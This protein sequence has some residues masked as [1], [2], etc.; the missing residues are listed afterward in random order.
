MGTVIQEVTVAKARLHLEKNQAFERG[1]EGTNRP[2]NLRKVNDYAV[3]MLKGNWRFTHQ[4]IGF[5]KK[6]FL[7]DGQHRLLAIL[8]A[9][10]VGATEGEVEYAPNP[11]IRIRM[12]VTEGLD[13]DVFDKLDTGL[14]RRSDQIL[15]IAGYY[16]QNRLASAARLLYLYDNHDYKFWNRVKVTNQEILNTVRTTDINEYLAISNLLAPV[17]FMA[18][19]VIVGSFLCERSYPTGA[20]LDFVESL[21]SGADLTADHPALALRNYVIRSKRSGRIRR[22]AFVHLA[23]YIKAW[24]D[25]CNGMLRQVVAFRSGED[26]P[27]PVER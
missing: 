12:L 19:S 15:A 7:I 13:D 18:S 1:T 2:I 22:D 11:K 26:F 8:Q 3:E 24:N 21:K 4:G 5:S 23:L 25:T 20:H 27:K 16:N 9:A 6:G 10:E 17:G 14:Q